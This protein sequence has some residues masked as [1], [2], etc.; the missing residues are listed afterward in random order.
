MVYKKSSFFV[1]NSLLLW[2]ELVHK[3]KISTNPNYLLQLFDLKIK[4][5]K[6]IALNL[7][8]LIAIINLLYVPLCF[9]LINNDIKITQHVH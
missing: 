8:T 1:S 9:N 6:L 5:L 2:S 3:F 7:Q 4:L